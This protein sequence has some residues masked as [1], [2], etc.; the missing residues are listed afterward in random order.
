[1]I[2][3]P[4]QFFNIE[5]TLYC[6]QVFRFKPFKN[7]YV[8]ISKNKVCYLY[9]D[10][11]FVV[12]ES[13]D[14]D[15]FYNYF[16][17]ATDYEK[18]YKK[19]LS[20]NVDFISKSAENGKGIRILKQ[21]IFEVVF[22]FIIS[23]N[24]NIPRIKRAI[25]GLSEKLGE[26]INAFSTEFYSFPTCEKL[27]L[28]SEEFFANLGLGYRAKYFVNTSNFLLNNDFLEK[29]KTEQ[30]NGL[31]EYLQ[32]LSGVG[33]KVAD[34]IMLFGYG[35]LNSFPV[36]TWIEKIYKENFNGKLTDRNKISQFFVELFGEYSGYIQQYVFYYKRGK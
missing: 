34:C 30:T 7:G 28:Q 27:A 3:Y 11:E 9:Y 23:Q 2:K 25:E 10:N 35:R 6:G 29:G 14:D 32:T 22:S 21:D 16:D 13:T 15:Y 24:N 8:V 4:K 19:I 1:M 31:R 12:L 18:V 33:P 17:L 36:D 26:K 5:D 20:Y